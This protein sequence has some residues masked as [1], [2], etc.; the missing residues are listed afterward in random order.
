MTLSCSCDYDDDPDW[1]YIPPDDYSTLNTKRRVRCASCYGLIDIGATVTEFT[2]AR[3]PRDE[4]E[5]RIYGE[6][7]EAVPLAPMYHCERCA[8]IYFSLYELGF[9]CI[10]PNEKMTELAS[11]YAQTYGAREA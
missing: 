8:D 3:P 4:I 5:E 1:I 9:T 2:R 11:E 7:Y 6:D 10:A